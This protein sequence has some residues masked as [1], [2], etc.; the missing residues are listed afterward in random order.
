MVM[1]AL[2]IPSGSPPLLLHHTESQI[3]RREA[4][5]LVEKVRGEIGQSKV[6]TLTTHLYR[7][8]HTST[9]NGPMTEGI[10]VPLPVYHKEKV[11]KRTVRVEFRL[12][13][14]MRK[15]SGRKIRSKQIEI[16]T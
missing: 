1:P 14:K 13:M 7:P 15:S 10:L 12:I 3:V 8:L 11:E 2:D 6:V 9:M 16:G 4:I 5:D